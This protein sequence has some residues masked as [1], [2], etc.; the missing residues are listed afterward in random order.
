M[1][2]QVNFCGQPKNILREKFPASTL[3]F[4]GRPNLSEAG[5]DLLNRLLALDPGQRITAQKALTHP[6]YG[7]GEGGVIVRDLQSNTP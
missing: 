4:E 2:L 5:F 7:K 1:H 6:W 3:S